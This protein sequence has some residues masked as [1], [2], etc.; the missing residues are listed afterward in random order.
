[1][2]TP[3]LRYDAVFNIDLVDGDSSER[4]WATKETPNSSPLGALREQASAAI[5]AA[6]AD[7]R[8]SGDRA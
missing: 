4:L 3:T 7:T 6:A 8:Y 1:M 5:A 2:T